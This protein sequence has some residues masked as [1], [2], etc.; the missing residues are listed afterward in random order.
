MSAACKDR[1]L[2][3]RVRVYNSV[4]DA[5]VPSVKYA[6]LRRGRHAL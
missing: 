4:I 6:W 2:A 3:C 5:C 1:E